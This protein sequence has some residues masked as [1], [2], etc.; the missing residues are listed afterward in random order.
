VMRSF[1]IRITPAG[2]TL[3]ARIG[4]ERIRILS[5]DLSKASIVP[6][7]GART[8]TV[9]NVVASLTGDGAAALNG[10][11]HTTAFAEGLV[12]GVAQVN[13]HAR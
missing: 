4:D 12:L 8:V 5:L 3:S 9:G 6:N 2:A 11:F 10:A 7:P 1:G 13:A